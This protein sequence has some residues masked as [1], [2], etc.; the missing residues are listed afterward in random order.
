MKRFLYFFFIIVFNASGFAQQLVDGFDSA[1]TDT[2]YWNMLIAYPAQDT[3]ILDYITS[4]VKVGSGA[5]KVTYHTSGYDSWGGFVGMEHWNPDTALT[6]DFSEYDSISFWYYNERPADQAVPFILRLCLFDVSDAPN[7][8]NTYALNQG[9]EK[10]FS[11]LNIMKTSPGWNYVSIPLVNNDNIEG[12]G[13]AL[14]TWGGGSL[15]N[16]TLDL[17]KIKG[18]VYEFIV[19]GQTTQI[20]SGTFIIDNLELK[21]LKNR[22]LVFFNGKKTPGDVS[23]MEGRGGSCVVSNEE[24]SN[25]ATHLFSLKWTTPGQWDGPIWTLNKSANL[26][27]VWQTDTLKFKI[28]APAGIGDL[29]IIFQDPDEDGAA[30]LDYPFEAAYILAADDVG[31][32]GSWKSINIPLKS[33]NRYAGVWDDATSAQVDGVMDSSKVLKFKILRTNDQR[34]QNQIVYLDEIW[35][36]NPVFDVLAPDAPQNI[37]AVAGTYNN[38]IIWEDVPYE[39]GEVYDV[40]VSTQPITDLTS[41]NVDRI[42]KKIAENV[43]QVEHVLIAPAIDQNVT[44]HYAIVCIDKAGNESIIGQS[45]SEVTNLAKGVPVINPSAPANFV[46]DGEFNDWDGIVPFKIAKSIGT[47]HQVDGSGLFIDN[48]ADLSFDIYLATDNDYLYVAGKVED[49]VVKEDSV[50]NPDLSY[51]YDGIDVFLGLYDWRGESHSAYKK[52]SETD[53]HFRFYKYGTILDQPGG[54]K[55]LEMTSTDYFWAENFPTGYRFEAKI[56]FTKIAGILGTSPVFKPAKGMRIPL[57]LIGNDNDNNPPGYTREGILTYSANSMDQS[58]RD[59]SVWTNTWIGD[60]WTVGVNDN[61]AIV[62][63][64]KLEQNYPNPF[65]PSTVISYSVKEP[66]LVTLKIYNVLGQVVKTLVNES[67]QTGIYYEK[68]DASTLS[69][70]IYIYQLKAG[71]FNSSKKM[72]LVK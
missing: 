14:R 45:M 32:N 31:Y 6:Y 62:L 48:D 54:G 51:L 9:A 17:D 60:Q 52:G 64:Y 2:A 61:K 24:T 42:A 15:G 29:R 25:P 26:S 5:M 55:V 21:G 49:N 37:Q 18:W 4:P 39:D 20:A 23:L 41:K 59:V 19:D 33:F 36:G 8:N 3:L 40:Y 63:N 66:G 12:K 11:F 67:K 57:D 1:P 34:W 46:V 47:G 69:S 70:G 22:S 30:T 38:L 7:G 50:D 72:M 56:P 35:T 28:K 58:Y 13:F 44:Y 53:Y 10:Y 27:K 71:S 65:N 16:N 68:F 43:Q